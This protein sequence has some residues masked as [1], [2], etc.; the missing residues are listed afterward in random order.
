MN[1]RKI[2]TEEKR[3]VVKPLVSLGLPVFNGENYLREAIES[4]LAQDYTNWEL[5]IFDNASEDA[6]G[7]IAREFAESDERIHYFRQA[8]NLGAVPNF[9]HTFEASSGQY[10]KWF[11]HDD[12]L[13]SDYLSRCIEVLENEPS[14]SLCHSWVEVLEPDGSIKERRGPY[15]PHADSHLL[16]ERLGAIMHN[17]RECYD[18]FGVMRREVLD[19]TGLF[20]SY[21]ASDRVLRLKIGLTGRYH[22][23]PEFLTQIRD[24]PSRSTRAMPAHHQRARWFHK[25]NRA[26]WVFPHWRIFG[27]YAKSLAADPASRWSFACWSQLFLWPLHSWNWARMGADIIIGVFPRSWEFLMALA[28]KIGAA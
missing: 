10:F 2:R 20:E 15:L 6:T 27:E 28:R 19:Q 21:I 18:I 8:E 24:H 3:W 9:N 4:V 12:R 16:G 11:A 26:D 22:E 23:V 17:D 14:V 25:D 5:L 1:S 7:A 13:R